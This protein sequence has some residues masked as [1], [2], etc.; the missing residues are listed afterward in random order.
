MEKRV[1]EAWKLGLVQAR[2]DK[3]VLCSYIES[4][5]MTP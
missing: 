5:D 1:P 3:T 2:L 4:L